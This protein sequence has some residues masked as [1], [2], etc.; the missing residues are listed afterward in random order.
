[1][2]RCIYLIVMLGTSCG[3]A[4]PTQ[5]RDSYK[6][7]DGYKVIRVFPRNQEEIQYLHGLSER[8]C[9]VMKSPRYP[10]GP[11]DVMCSSTKTNKFKS[12]LN[13]RG[14]E[15]EEIIKNMGSL[16]RS[17]E[18]KKRRASRKRK[19]T[20]MNWDDYQRYKTIV[21]WMR[22]TVKD[23]P[24]F[25]TL[26]RMGRSVE[27][28]GIFGLKIGSSPLGTE[29]RALWI[30]GGIHAREWIAIS[31]STYI[32]KKLIDTFSSEQTSDPVIQSVDWYIAPLLN[33]D[34]YEYTHTD[35]RLWRKNRR[36]PPEG[37][38]K[39]CYG[40][41]LNRNFGTTGFGIGASNRTCSEVYWGTAENSEPE[42]MAVQKT[43][44]KYKNNIRVYITFHSYGQSWLTSWG[45]T[46]DLPEDYDKLYALARR[47]A[48]A[49]ESVNPKREYIVGA[50][51]AALYLVGGAT[52]DWAKKSF[53]VD[54]AEIIPIGEEL[55][56]AMREM[57]TEAANHPLGND[58]T[59]F[60]EK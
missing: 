48:D 11:M 8:L 41:D 53:V 5:E 32:I 22:K 36:E 37:D 47:G 7:Y 50:G 59:N 16:I 4:R 35:Q 1:M 52:D 20:K 15:I 18:T 29:T 33:P 57:A 42:T 38:K 3:F 58:S 19:K 13:K 23:N 12:I 30:D 17:I 40:V 24:S 27:G 6:N 45:Y 54:P 49:S 9:E 21:K 10:G 60:K 14:I 46:S 34:G 39:N 55:W 43:I 26:I 28:R 25:T 31:T 56:A 2:L 44:L 51:G